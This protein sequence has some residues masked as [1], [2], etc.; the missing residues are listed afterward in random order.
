MLTLLGT[1]GLLLG[2]AVGVPLVA[3]GLSALLDRDNWRKRGGSPGLGG[4][5]V[6]PTGQDPTKPLAPMS[7]SNDPGEP[8]G[9]VS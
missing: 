1:L 5:P 8:D 6:G 3:Y 2:L 9:T 7:R 4:R